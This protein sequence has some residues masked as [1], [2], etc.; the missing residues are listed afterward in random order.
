MVW[1]PTILPTT[2]EGSRFY[3]IENSTNLLIGPWTA[4][5]PCTDVPATSSPQVTYTNQATFS[6]QFYRAKVRLSAP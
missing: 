6:N 4:I 3:T 2:Q 5:L 1:V